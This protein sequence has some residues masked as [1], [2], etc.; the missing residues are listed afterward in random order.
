MNTIVKQDQKFIG[1]RQIAE[2]TGKDHH[3]VMADV[4]RMA[5]DAGVTIRQSNSNENSLEIDSQDVVII[6]HVFEIKA[7]HTKRV[8]REYLLNEMA[9]ELLATGYDV[10]RR[11]AVLKLIRNIKTAIFEDPDTVLRLAQNWRDEKQRRLQAERT[12]ELQEKTI[13]ESKPKIKYHDEVLQSEGFIAISVIAKELGVSAQRLNKFLK[14]HGVQYRCNGTWLLKSKYQDMGYT[15]ILTIPYL[16]KNMEQQTSRQT[17]WTEKGRKFIHELWR[18][19][20][21]STLKIFQDE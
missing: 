12:I 10:K 17:Y 13:D 3:H 4:R 5:E 14:V 8:T 9:A 20:N 21:A 6:E 11:L 2:A 18:K 15:K 16:D 1:S 19:H 7:V